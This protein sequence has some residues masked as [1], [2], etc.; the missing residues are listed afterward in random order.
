MALPLRRSPCGLPCRDYF[1]RVRV[2]GRDVYLSEWP[3]GNLKVLLMEG[4]GVGGSV[5]TLE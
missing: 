5:H 2:Q 1:L 3:A 4:L